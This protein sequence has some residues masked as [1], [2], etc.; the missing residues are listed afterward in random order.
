MLTSLP[1]YSQNK[2]GQELSSPVLLLLRLLLLL[3]LLLMM[4]M[5]GRLEG[6]RPDGG[7]R[8]LVRGAEN[9][10]DHHAA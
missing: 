5:L 3:L 7:H 8:H 4:M 2:P 6:G 1:W 10:S 9:L